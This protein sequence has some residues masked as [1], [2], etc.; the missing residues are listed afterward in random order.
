MGG[1][2]TGDMGAASEVMGA[3]PTGEEGGDATRTNLGFLRWVNATTNN[4]GQPSLTP[5]AVEVP[6]FTIQTGVLT[7]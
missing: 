6:G 2:P 4:V 1:F 3:F 7:L 5:R